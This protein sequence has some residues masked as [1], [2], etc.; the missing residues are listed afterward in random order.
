MATLTEIVM[1]QRAASEPW[2][3]WD[4]CAPSSRVT[5]RQSAADRLLAG[6]QGLPVPPAGFQAEL[7][8]SSSSE[9]SAEEGSVRLP[10]ERSMVVPVF[11]PAL[12][13]QRAREAASSDLSLEVLAAAAS[14]LQQ[15][16]GLPDGSTG[17]AVPTGSGAG[18]PA[19]G[20]RPP[21]P[22]PTR[23]G[24]LHSETPPPGTSH[25]SVRAERTGRSPRR[26]GLGITA[27][28]PL[29]TPSGSKSP[30]MARAQCR[31]TGV[32][33]TPLSLAE[34]PRS[35]FSDIDEGPAMPRV[36]FNDN[37]DDTEEIP[38][39]PPRMAKRLPVTQCSG[40]DVR[41]ELSLGLRGMVTLDNV[42]PP[43]R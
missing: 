40:H 22:P 13:P 28:D 16:G 34:T 33:V 36:G 20:S 5:S 14:M 29:R 1:D 11:G 43:G 12:H 23:F 18:G 9:G 31:A 37:F 2:D 4:T 17:G 30:C 25:V 41:R 42:G 32:C 26:S 39:M 21:L 8:S 6:P 3:L 15:T 10:N 38:I 19:A 27:D 7:G 24:P 35:L